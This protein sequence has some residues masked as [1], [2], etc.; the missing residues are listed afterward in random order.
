MAR[1]VIA[2]A[3]TLVRRDP[4]FAIWILVSTLHFP[5]NRAIRWARKVRR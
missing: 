2:D 5:L 1:D 3:R 4:G